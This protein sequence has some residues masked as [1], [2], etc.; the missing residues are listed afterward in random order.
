MNAEVADNVVGA[1]EA[2][3]EAPDPPKREEAKYYG[4]WCEKR[5]EQ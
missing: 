4:R 3:K 5:R 1:E 2:E